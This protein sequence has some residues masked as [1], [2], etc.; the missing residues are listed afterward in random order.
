MTGKDG[1]IKEVD[2][3]EII[4]SIEKP[5]FSFSHIINPSSHFVSFWDRLLFKIATWQ[6][7]GS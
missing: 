1:L 6:P 3:L 2:M 7:A 4:G 5:F